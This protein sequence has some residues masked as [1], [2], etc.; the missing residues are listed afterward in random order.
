MTILDESCTF[1]KGSICDLNGASFDAVR[2]QGWGL[3]EGAGITGESGQ[4]VTVIH[5]H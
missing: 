3:L 2:K 1:I 5:L 4:C